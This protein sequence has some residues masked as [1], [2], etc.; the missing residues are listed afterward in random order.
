M[1][2]PRILYLSFNVGYMN[3]TRKC[4]VK[5]LEN[6]SDLYIYGPGYVKNEIINQKIE[7][8]ISEE[9]PFD[10]IIADE[11]VIQDFDLQN[12]ESNRFVNHACRFDPQLLIKALE[13]RKFL[14]KYQ[15][16]KIISLLQS[17]YYNFPKAHIENLESIGDYFLC[18][19]KELVQSKA[20]LNINIDNL[21]G[22][23]K[24]IVNKWNDNFYN[25]CQRNY[26]KIISCPHFINETEMGGLDL[27]QRSYAWSCLGA[28]Y[29]SRVVARKNID[30][31]KLSRSGKWLPYYFSF[32]NRL[33]INPYN[34]Y[35]SIY[36]IQWG[37]R[38]AL[39]Q[40]KYA[41]TCGSIL[42]WPIRKYFEIPANGG[43]LVCEKPEGYTELGFVDK[44]NSMICKPEEILHAYDWLESDIERS[45]IIVNRAKKMI[46]EKHSV[47][48]R[49]EQLAKALDKI[50]L[51]EFKG[52]SWKNGCFNC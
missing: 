24:N 39:R 3:P 6:I 42:N 38:R 20:E 10:Y 15:G 41:F 11:Y 34:K 12:I 1:S 4:L 25:F 31:V 16:K 40:A 19:G 30:S 14:A 51:G 17:D 28:D 37:F 50:A 29:N 13:W 22:I 18:W 23:N 33:N 2:R 43:V 52:A 49:S 48:A 47:Q 45:Q 46:I 5:V 44:E 7:K 32:A 9:G 26:K 36:L 35:W 8:V 21:L 27:T